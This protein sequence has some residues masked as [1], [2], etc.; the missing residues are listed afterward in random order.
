ML[1]RKLT[2]LI[3]KQSAATGPLERAELQRFGSCER[4][5]LV[6]E[7]LAGDQV[8]AQR[9]AVNRDKRA[10]PPLALLV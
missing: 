7:Q 2:D 4:A 1:G 10:I 9:S 5:S 8:R 3:E 6:P